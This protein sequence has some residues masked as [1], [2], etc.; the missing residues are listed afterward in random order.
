MSVHTHHRG[1][2]GGESGYVL[3]RFPE[4]KEVKS[5]TNPGYERASWMKC[6]RANPDI[7]DDVLASHADVLTLVTRKNVCVGGS[8]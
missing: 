6:G 1:E 8:K 7:F 4:W 3:I 5:V 2:F